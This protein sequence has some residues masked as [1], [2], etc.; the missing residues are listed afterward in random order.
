MEVQTLSTAAPALEGPVT[1]K[2][3]DR[4]TVA[5]MRIRNGPIELHVADDGDPAAPPVLLLH[6]IT[7][8]SRTWDWLVPTLVDRF[9]VL[10]LD[11]RGHGD[12]D[13]APG[14]YDTAGYVSDAV[15]VCEQVAAQPCIVIGHSLG[16]ATAAALAQ[17]R[18][19]LVRAAIMEDPPLGQPRTSRD[20][21][22][23]ALLDGF[24]LLRTSIPRLQASGVT[25]DALARILA[26]LPG[27]SGALL[28]ETLHADGIASMAGSM[29]AVDATVLDPILGG[30]IGTLLDQAAPL[31]APS[32]IVCADPAT[33]DAVADPT[34]AHH[35]ADLSPATE[36]IVVEGAGHLIHDGLASRDAFRTASLAF[37]DRLGVVAS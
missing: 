12:S 28:G 7:S 14:D 22:G 21:P 26:S 19:D 18:P 3:G 20:R 32:L 24:R 15:A 36:V 9:R 37:V 1:A 2:T 8:Y 4:S 29:L 33:A 16:G 6:G 11:F 25:R 30:T 27:A 13:R 17:R 31:G 10:R 23:Q 5:G 35:I 34:L